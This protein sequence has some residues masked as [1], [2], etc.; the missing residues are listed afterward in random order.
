[1]DTRS[2]AEIGSVWFLCAVMAGIVATEKRR[3]FWVWFLFGAV[4]GPIALY[5]AVRAYEAVPPEEAMICP[6]CKKPI[7]KTARHCPRCK[8][9]LVAEPDRVMKAGR[10]AAAAVFLLRR[11]AKKSTAAVKAEQAKRARA[12]SERAAGQE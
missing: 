7:R 3:R 12:K 9:V 6:S 2:W 8:Y 4:T 10:Q 1:M 5:L 11:A